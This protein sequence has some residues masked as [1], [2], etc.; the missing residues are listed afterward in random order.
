[1]KRKSMIALGMAAVLAMGTCVPVLA[2]STI[3]ETTALKTADTNIS[4]DVSEKY[5][6]TIPA[7]ATF[8]TAE[9][10][11]ATDNKIVIEVKDVVLGLKKALEV[12]A[13]GDKLTSS[14]LSL[15]LENG[16]ENDKFDVMLD[17]TAVSFDKAGEET[18]VLTSTDT[19]KIAGMYKST[20]TFTV[21][22]KTVS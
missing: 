10:P 7:Q 17:K 21:A 13:S 14:T 18:I 12:T 1:M 22:Q 2:D 6:V 8:S 20:L 4:L 15:M 16:T 11:E 3:T 19:A 5:S 9:K